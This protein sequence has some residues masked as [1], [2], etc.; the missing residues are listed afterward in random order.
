MKHKKTKFKAGDLIARLSPD[1]LESFEPVAFDNPTKTT[2]PYC[3]VGC[4]VMI[5][6]SA[7]GEVSLSGDKNHP[8]NQG[9]LCT[10]GQSLLSTLNT[11]TRIATPLVN[12]QK[13]SWRTAVDLAASKFKACIDEFGKESVAFYVSG[14]LLTEDYYVAN[15][16]MK[17]F[18]GSANIDTNSR[19]CMASPVIAHKKA[20]GSDTV[21]VNYS[22]LDKADL[23]LL[24]GSN[25]AWCHPVLF[26]RIKQAKQKNANLKVVVV[27]PRETASCEIAD[28]H[29]AINTGTDLVLFNR[30][31]VYLYENNVDS[32]Q[33][34]NVNHIYEAYSAA[35]LD[36][37]NYSDIHTEL[38][39]SELQL[40]TFLNWFAS[41]QKVVTIFSQGVNQSSS[42]VDN[43][44]SIINCHL[45]TGKIGKPGAGPFSITGQPNAMGGREVGAMASSLASHLDFNQESFNLLEGFWQSKN[46]ARQPGL[47]AVDMFEQI[48]Q[49]K[50]KAI[51]IMATNPVA[52]L[53]NS[54]K[55]KKALKLCPDRKS[56][57]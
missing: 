48:L 56:V 44:S 4:G 5:S 55:I 38:G 28:L 19:L 14:Q 53:P 2:C 17:G 32:C 30:L 6:K 24:V 8:A 52:T 39:I 33:D 41:N 9:L 25:L 34:A 45:L 47:K 7:D 18:I 15:K 10:K 3:G 40:E 57:V 21:P 11:D 35:K 46:I 31:L 37:D 26:Q 27:D 20:F 49:G 13:S 43:C 29:L 36:L 42:G 16:L 1:R 12:Q 22:D 50:I 51:W 23:I 54:E